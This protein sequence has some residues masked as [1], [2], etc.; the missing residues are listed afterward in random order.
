MRNR[1]KTLLR[2][3]SVQEVTLKACLRHYSVS[4]IPETLTIRGPK[5]P[6]T[7]PPQEGHRIDRDGSAV[8]S[9]TKA[10]DMEEVV[11]SRNLLP[12]DQAVAMA[13]EEASSSKQMP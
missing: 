5:R 11:A 13:E 4:T 10:G 3:H 7:H 2:D 6:P 9:Q 12:K 8:T 1:G